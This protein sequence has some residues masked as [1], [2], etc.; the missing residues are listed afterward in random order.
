MNTDFEIND[1]FRVMEN[2]ELIYTLSNSENLA[3]QSRKDEY[4]DSNDLVLSDILEQLTP[5]RKKIAFAAIEL[6]KRMREEQ[7][8]KYLLKSSKEI[9]ELM[10]PCLN[11]LETEEIWVLFFNQAARLIK[12]VRL[13]SGGLSGA[14]FDIRVLMKLAVKY[15]AVSFILVHNHPS[16]NVRPSSQDDCTTQCA[17]KAGE[18]MQINLLDHIIIGNNRSDYY[19]YADEGKLF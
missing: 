5:A 6:Y 15:N 13:A 3:Y 14:V 19:S 4:S 8:P 7:L 17:K 16:G 11:D 9:F 2:S 12:K 1:T 18:L 10:L